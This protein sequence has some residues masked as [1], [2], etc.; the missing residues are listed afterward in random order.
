[1]TSIVTPNTVAV[2]RVGR[3]SLL[4]VTT[5]DRFLRFFV[6]VLCGYAVGS[7]GFAYLGVPPFFIG[8]LSLA[9]GLVAVWCARRAIRHLPIGI[10]SVLVAFVAF[11]AIRTVPF[12]GS[13][14]LMALR[15]AALYGS[16]GMDCSP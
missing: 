1:M 8:E 15:D 7:K 13:Y 10:T 5:V 11:S 16:T 14:G 3:R 4:G 12:L 9:F 6:V 2:P